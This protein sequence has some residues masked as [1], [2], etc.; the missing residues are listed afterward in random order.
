MLPYKII[1]AANGDA[2]VQMGDKAYAPPQIAAMVLQKIKQ[3]SEAKLGRRS[4]SR[5][6]CACLLQ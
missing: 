1:R 6:H 5:H 3:D 2:H 4:G